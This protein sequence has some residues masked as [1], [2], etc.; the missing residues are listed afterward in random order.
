MAVFLFNAVKYETVSLDEYS[1]NL[2]SR[3]NEYAVLKIF[4]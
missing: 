1:T 2:R 4:G 3:E